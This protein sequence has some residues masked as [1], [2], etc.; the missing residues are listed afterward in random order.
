MRNTDTLSTSRLR[1]G[2]IG[3]GSMGQ[4]H[5][6][7]YST[8][9]SVDLV[10]VYDVDDDTS[11]KMADQ[12]GCVSFKNLVE[13]VGKVDAVSICSPSS[14]HAEHGLFFLKNKINCLV[15]KPLATTEED[16]QSLITAAEKSGALLMVGHIE[17]FNPAV[18]L[19]EKIIKSG[20]HRI[21]G[22]DANRMSM[23]SSRIKDVDVVADLMVH[24]LD[25]VLSLMDRA[26]DKIVANGISAAPGKKPDYVNT[27][28]SFGEGCVANITA[29]RVTHN[30]IRD[31]SVSSDSGYI[32][33]DYMNQDLHI[34]RQDATSSLSTDDIFPLDISLE[35]AMIRRVEPL[36]AELQNFVQAS[37][38]NEEPK[39]TGADGLA[40]LKLVQQ[41]QSLVGGGE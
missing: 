33:I 25:I 34:Y 36:N 10:G 3:T 7:V 6:R 18:Q 17:R 40:A 1:V 13:M 28:L 22:I 32:T 16:C 9:K 5:V 14:L 2:I 23:V 31:L 20:K 4:N 11:Q 39:V 26:P 12:Y 35:R 21:Y 19:L 24:D 30:R 37:F 41:V 29:S 15:E 8:L 27:L 38:G